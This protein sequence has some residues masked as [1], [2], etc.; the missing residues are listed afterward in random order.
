M[1]VDVDRHKDGVRQLMCSSL[2]DHELWIEDLLPKHE[3]TQNQQNKFECSKLS[4][5]SFGIY[6]Y[7]IIELGL[8]FYP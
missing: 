2:Y 4:F 1:P 5:L 6:G 7:D 8:L 3:L